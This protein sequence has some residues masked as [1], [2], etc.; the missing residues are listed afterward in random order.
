MNWTLVA[1]RF[2]MPPKIMKIVFGILAFL[3][4]L[5]MIGLVV[6]AAAPE[7]IVLH[8]FDSLTGTGA[9]GI[10][11]TN[12]A[13]MGGFFY[14]GDKY[15]PG[16]CTYWV[17]ARRAQVGQPIPNTW[18]DAA[19]WAPRA[20]KDGYSVDHI[21]T[22]YAIMQT[23]NSAGGLGHVAFV[24]KVDPDGTWHISEMNVLGLYIVDD[25]KIPP[26]AAKA[27]NFIHEKVQ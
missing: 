19:T 5:P 13:I 11:P 25:K 17:Y 24:E 18:G 26:D 10:K 21:P 8:A 15:A 23:S 9:A 3:I 20:A 6:V 1:L 7:A 12:A 27:Y 14:P 4:A 22:Q 2:L 16:N